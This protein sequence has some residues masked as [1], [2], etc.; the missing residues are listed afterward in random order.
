MHMNLNTHLHMYNMDLPQKLALT[1]SFPSSCAWIPVSLFSST[2]AY[3]PLALQP[4]SSCWCRPA[5]SHTRSHTNTQS[6]LGLPWHPIVPRFSPLQ[7]HTPA[8][9]AP[10]HSRYYSLSRN[11]WHSSG[12]PRS[13]KVP[14][15]P[16][17]SLMEHLFPLDP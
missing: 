13:G 1:L 17:V 10:T 7:T 16:G 11:C 8:G 15:H 9:L 4:L 5:H 2:W 3:K 6:W 12:F 14:F